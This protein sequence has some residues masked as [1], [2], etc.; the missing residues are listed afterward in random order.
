MKEKWHPA[1]SSFFIVLP[2]LNRRLEADKYGRAENEEFTM[3]KKSVNDLLFHG[4][5]RPWRHVFRSSGEHVIIDDLQLDAGFGWGLNKGPES[6]QLAIIV[7]KTVFGP[8]LEDHPV[9]CREFRDLVIAGLPNDKNWMLTSLDVYQA[10]QVIL[11]NR[12]IRQANEM[13]RRTISTFTRS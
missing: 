12:V 1:T 8:H 3:K 10:C 9:S 7:L 6:I 2:N 5:K 11:D 13:E 4:W